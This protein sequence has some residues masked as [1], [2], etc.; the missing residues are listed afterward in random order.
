MHLNETLHDVVDGVLPPAE[1]DAT[2]AAGTS[3]GVQSLGDV[4]LTLMS[5]MNILATV[6]GNILLIT[7]V[8]V[9]RRLRKV[10]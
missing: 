1:S 10:R 9:E 4:Y 6:L 8:C 5:T 3:S 7:A 2:E